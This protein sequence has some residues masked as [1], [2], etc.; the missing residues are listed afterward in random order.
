VL[1]NSFVLHSVCR[2]LDMKKIWLAGRKSLTGFDLRALM[3]LRLMR[4][5]ELLMWRTSR[6]CILCLQPDVQ[7][8][9]TEKTFALCWAFMLSMS[10]TWMG[11]VNPEAYNHRDGS[12]WVAQMEK[13]KFIWQCIYQSPQLC[14]SHPCICLMCRVIFLYIDKWVLCPSVMTYVP[15]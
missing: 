4:C 1:S 6:P 10:A 15:G 13:R 9:W 12:T 3:W 11:S 8:W 5:L 14:T 2:L 7:W